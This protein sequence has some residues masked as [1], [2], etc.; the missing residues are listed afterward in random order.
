[1]N[2]PLPHH[3]AAVWFADIV[4]YTAQS[5][6]DEAVAQRLV[7]VFTT[8]TRSVATRYGG[9]V[10][11]FLGDGAL[12]EFPS[13]E[14]AVRSAWALMTA[15]PQ[16]AESGGF[17]EQRLRIGVHVG[18]VAQGADGDLFGDGV[19]VAS[20]LQG[21]AEAGEVWVSE[22]VRRQLRQRREFAFESRGER[23]MKG[24]DRPI[25]I[26]AVEVAG[27]E[28]WVPIVPRQVAKSR[29][30]GAADSVHWLHRLPR[31]AL[32]AAA[33]GLMLLLGLAAWWLNREPSASPPDIPADPLPAAAVGESPDRSI[34]VLPF[35]NL[36]PDSS[37]AFFAAGIAD[38]IISALA[39]NQDM[40]V[41]S[42]TS[43]AQY[44]GTTK[45]MRQIAQE[46]G[47]GNVLE[48]SVRRVGNRIRI[49]VQLI[50]AR[51]DRHL[52][53]ETYDRELTDVFAVQ[54]DIAQTVAR[55]LRVTMSAEASERIAA[56][57]TQDV[58]AYALYLQ[59]RNRLYT[60]QRDF[61][62]VEERIREAMRFFEDATRRD[63]SYAAAW[64]GLGMGYAYL[65]YSL[66]R[67]FADSAESMASR[68]LSIDSTSAQGYVALGWTRI[69][70][71]RDEESID[72]ALRA[73]RFDPN[74]TE[75][76]FLAA[77]ELWWLGRL[78]EAL[79]LALKAV[80]LDPTQMGNYQAVASIYTDLQLYE[81]AEQWARRMTALEPENG[82]GHIYLA[83]LALMRGDADGVAQ[84][85]ALA[86]S[87]SP[88]DRT[89]LWK[90]F[91]HDA[92]RGDFEAARHAGEL[93]AAGF[94][95][96]YRDDVLLGY[97]YERLGDR[98]R[99]ETLYESKGRSDRRLAE[100]EN[101][102]PMTYIELARL[103]TV[104]GDEKEAI[105]WLGIAYDRGF[106]QLVILRLDPILAHLGADSEYRALVKRIENDV[107]RMRERV[108]TRP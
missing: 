91:L 7:Q 103:A 40:E 61:E 84:E 39:R 85:L 62:R 88:D 47:V 10:V 8:S 63:P 70:Q 107:A 4:G 31:S 26:H 32:V 93:L 43:T 86:R 72:L 16:A 30:Q 82:V 79:P 37:D 50:D 94:A 33:V 14:L 81:E 34:A 51:T 57:G 69:V 42:R 2:A 99:A 73:L 13:T 36:S 65:A 83:D 20:R 60:S 38:D 76:L 75:A 54:S 28:D 41:I 25:E 55:A 49:V 105:E 1:M 100:V 5:D 46:L 48:G 19:N 45:P 59:G 108:G 11:K 68:A 23:T 96:E 56:G 44:E 64:A 71:G 52:W 74:N 102:D 27:E 12:V 90:G 24:F 95:I 29:P 35:E 21:M 98:E 92:G 18:D 97:C 104:R 80:R 17:G 106:R 15:F 22:D 78:D 58:D 3:L 6:S 101:D 77:G 53:S 67:S 66:E 9:R 89:V 87:L